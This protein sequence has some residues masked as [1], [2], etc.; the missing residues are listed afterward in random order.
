VSKKIL[1]VSINS[2]NFTLIEI[3]DT[4]RVCRCLFVLIFFGISR[5]YTSELGEKALCPGGYF[6][7]D[8]II[9]AKTSLLFRFQGRR[10]E[11][12]RRRPGVGIV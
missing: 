3:G 11:L 8:I 10:Q 5:K 7:E 2:F 12:C 6:E 1:P 9:R 4:S